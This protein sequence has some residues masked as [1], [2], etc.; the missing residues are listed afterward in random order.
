M[1]Q[2][3]Q[4]DPG[5]GGLPKTAPEARREGSPGRKPWVGC[6]IMTS[7]GGAA[8]VS[9]SRIARVAPALLPVLVSCSRAR[10]IAGRMVEDLDHSR[11][12]LCLNLTHVAPALLPVLCS[13]C[14]WASIPSFRKQVCIRA[15]LQS[16]RQNRF[17][18]GH[19]FIRAVRTQLACHLDQARRSQRSWRTEGAWRDPDSC[20]LAH[21]DTRC[22]PPNCVRCLFHEPKS[23]GRSRKRRTTQN[24][25]GAGVPGKPGFGLLGWGGAL[26]R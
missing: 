5:S 18:S 14:G 9:E 22:S 3:V 26:R 8:Q 15:R 12:R 24:S 6:I 4:G 25:A 11:P 10:F 20:V 23:S 17:V 21:A 1:N 19:G 13:S 2:K 7:P 16:C